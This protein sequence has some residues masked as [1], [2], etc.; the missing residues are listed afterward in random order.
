MNRRDLLSFTALALPLSA[1][2]RT[3]SGDL[4]EENLDRIA[5]SGDLTLER[6]A[7]VSP[8]DAYFVPARSLQELKKTPTWD[9]A[10]AEAYR[11]KVAPGIDVLSPTPEDWRRYASQQGWSEMD[12]SYDPYRDGYVIR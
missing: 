10:L 8:G 9:E 12:V 11:G 3:D 4:T 1:L 2:G 5:A 7:R 6:E